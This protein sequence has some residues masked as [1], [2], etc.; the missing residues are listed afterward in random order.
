MAETP[1]NLLCARA[2][3]PTDPVQL[4]DSAEEVV[5]FEDMRHRQGHRQW[6]TQVAL[7]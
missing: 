4:D 7:R 2:F 5:I 6:R 3:N 1:T